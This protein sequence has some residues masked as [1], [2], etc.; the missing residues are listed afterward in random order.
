[1]YKT[2]LPIKATDDLDDSEFYGFSE[3]SQAIR[4]FGN[5]KSKKK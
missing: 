5:L 1:M 3:I 2:A 4:I